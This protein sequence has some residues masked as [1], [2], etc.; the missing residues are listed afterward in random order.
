MIVR[1]IFYKNH[2]MSANFVKEQLNRMKCS[3]RGC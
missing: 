1:H 3:V 2:K